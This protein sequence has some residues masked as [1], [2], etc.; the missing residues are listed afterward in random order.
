MRMQ[1]IY[2]WCIETSDDGDIVDNDFRDK[3]TEF[4]SPLEANQELVL[5]RNEGNFDQGLKDRL[6][7]YVKNGKLPEYFYNSLEQPTGYKVPL[8]YHSELANYLK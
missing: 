7:A 4:T 3:L 1:V 6:W 8:K 5:V 2:E